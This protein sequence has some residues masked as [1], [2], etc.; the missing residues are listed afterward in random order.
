MAA[1]E[2]NLGIFEPKP[3]EEIQDSDWMRFFEVNVLSGARLS[4]LCLPAMK[5]ANWEQ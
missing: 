2:G 5:R 1:R 3:F 4:R